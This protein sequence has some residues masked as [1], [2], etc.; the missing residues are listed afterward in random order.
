MSQIHEFLREA[1]RIINAGQSRSLILYG[2]VHDLF[3]LHDSD[4]TTYVNLSTLL[5]RQW[6]TSS[7]IVIT[8]EPNGLIRIPDEH[9]E[10]LAEAWDKLRGV[11]DR[12]DA[13]IKEMLGHKMD[14]PA[15]DL[16]SRIREAIGDT[17]KAMEILRQ[18]TIASRD[19]HISAH[20]ILLIENADYI[21]PEGT[22]ASLSE[23]DRL[24]VGHVQE[25]FSDPAFSDGGDSVILIAEA[26]SQLNHRIT[27]LPQT[28][29]VEI[30]APER[31][32]RLAY[33]AWF[34]QSLPSDK[35]MPAGL[36][37][38]E[39]ASLTAG[40]SLFA[41]RQLLKGAVYREEPISHAD[42][43]SKVEDY[44]VDQIGGDVVE[45]KKPEH[46][47]ADVVGASRLRAFL[48]EH[49]IPR[50]RSEGA[51]ALAG[52]AVA[53]PIGSGKSFIFEAV[54]GELGIVV[55]TIK[56]VRSQ[57]FGQTDVLF[58]KLRRVLK[59]IGRAL[60]FIDEADTQFG[61]VG[62][63]DHPTERRLTG[64]M[65]EL[66]SDPKMKGKITWLLITARI[67]L[68]SPD[69]RRPGRAGSLI[70]PVLDPVGDDQRAFA[71]WAV[72]KAL[73]EP[74]TEELLDKLGG[75]TKGYSAAMYAGLRGELLSRGEKLTYEDVVAIIEDSIPPAI[76]QTRRYQTLQ[77]LVNCTRKSLLP[78]PDNYH[79]DQRL[80]WMAEIKALE[81]LG[82]S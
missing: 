17:L 6:S 51:D 29:S 77:A 80:G 34:K 45:F 10:A 56:N 44:I 33:I 50:L 8:Y 60:I 78:D 23:K 58:E 49:F 69:L 11:E 43:I 25:W 41:L 46:S 66:M 13:A 38:D 18:L 75:L 48:Q 16:D 54:A 3:A 32:E 65:Q 7:H 24:R 5:Q 30:G 79:P 74:V 42:V 62:A 26:Y 12:R 76:E 19:G 70:I 72:E 9:K 82:V 55:L 81:E 1:G 27:H 64:K 37:A 53:G 28:L 22:I 68:L 67:H 71:T 35:Q 73:Q 4:R 15:P 40:L 61:R 57:W 20:L 47:L 52:A 36:T 31:D 59:S 63:N 39:L 21:L 14:K 2:N